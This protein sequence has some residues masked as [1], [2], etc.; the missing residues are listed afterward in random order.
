M[1]VSL[2]THN[3]SIIGGFVSKIDTYRQQDESGDP[4]ACERAPYIFPDKFLS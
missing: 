2:R 1:T 3:G 4:H